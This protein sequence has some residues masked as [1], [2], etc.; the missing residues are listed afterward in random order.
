V[1]LLAI[2]PHHLFDGPNAI[3]PVF[4]EVLDPSSTVAGASTR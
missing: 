4:L 1:F 2:I 3:R